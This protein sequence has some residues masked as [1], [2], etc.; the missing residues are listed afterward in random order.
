MR[1][2]AAVGVVVGLVLAGTA[3]AAA[4]IPDAAAVIHGC[5][6]IK[7]GELRVIDTDAG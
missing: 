3:M 5:R 1:G 2:F 4:S 6:D 7:S